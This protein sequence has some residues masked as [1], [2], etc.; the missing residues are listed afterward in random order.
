MSIWAVQL[1]LNK[2]T[3]VAAVSPKK[4]I[5]AIFTDSLIETLL[6]Y[7]YMQLVMLA[8]FGQVQCEGEEKVGRKGRGLV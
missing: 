4:A 2:L 5:K 1:S 8:D 7:A 6:L 3:F